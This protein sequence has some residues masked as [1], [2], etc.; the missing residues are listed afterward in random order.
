M[1]CRL[2]G[3]GLNRYCYCIM[4]HLFQNFLQDRRVY[5]LNEQYYN[6]LF[7]RMLNKEVSPF[8][9]TTFG[10]GDPFFDGNPIF[11]ALHGGRIVRIIQHEASTTP[12]LK[13]WLDEFDGKQ[14]LVLSTELTDEFLQRIRHLI[15]QWWI[16]KA[17]KEEMEKVIRNG[18]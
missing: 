14:E 10:N 2:F 8:Y 16:E 1:V 17:A 15:Q 12:R 4:K 7:S 5:R 11:S 6:N 18:S 13:V 9:N 3:Y